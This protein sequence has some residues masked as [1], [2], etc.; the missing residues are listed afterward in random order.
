M[1]A[2]VSTYA[3]QMIGAGA[4]MVLLTLLALIFGDYAGELVRFR[5]WLP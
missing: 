3:A 1:T 2:L 4:L 5:K